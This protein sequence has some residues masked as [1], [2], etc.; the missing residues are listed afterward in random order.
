MHRHAALTALVLLCASPGCGA[1][2]P[3]PDASVTDAPSSDAATLDAMADATESDA[4]SDVA[5]DVAR[6]SASDAATGDARVLAAGRYDDQRIT[7]N[8]VE[9]R[10]DLVVPGAAATDRPMVLVF[11][12]NGGTAAALSGRTATKSPYSLLNAIGAREGFV[13][14]YPQGVD[15][16]NGSPGFNDCRGDATT[17]PTV[18][19]VA[20]VEALVARAVREWGVSARRVVA[21]G[22]S[23]GGHFSLRLAIER[24]TLVRAVAPIAAA[25]PAMS[26]CAAP[27]VAMPVLFING[28]MDPILRYTGGSVGTGGRGTTL[29]VQ[30]SVDLWAGLAAATRTETAAIP[31]GPL[32]DRCT[33][34]RVRRAGGRVAV[35]LIRVDGGG[36]TE[37]SARERYIP[38][39]LAVVG[40]Q[41][42]DLETADTLWSFFAPIVA[43]L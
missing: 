11:H 21:T 27:T 38:A 26:E 20:F 29:S 14:V 30:A 32:D 34:T 43:G 35:E 25:M 12:G 33:A 9:R 18:D 23:N 1:G 13:V 17:N 8:G 16:S 3:S 24:P 15:A 19:D 4:S 31:D 7:V 2:A 28:T 40:A 6:D 5:S 39:F 10:F 41:N 37:P 36:H 22:I 42:G